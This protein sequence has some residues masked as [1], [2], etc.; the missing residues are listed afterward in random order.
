MC[1]KRNINYLP[2]NNIKLIWS[3]NNNKS[4]VIRFRFNCI[5]VSFSYDTVIR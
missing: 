3:N 2:K 4:H 1:I 5:L